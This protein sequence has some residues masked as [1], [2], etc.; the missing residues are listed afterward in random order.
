VGVFFRRS[1]LSVLQYCNVGANDG[2]PYDFYPDESAKPYYY[3]EIMQTNANGDS[4]DLWYNLFQDPRF[5]NGPSGDFYL[6]WDSPCID[7][8][9]PGSTHDPD[10][11]VIDIGA[12]YRDALKTAKDVILPPSSFI[13]SNYPNPFNSAT[14][15]EFDLPR[16][17]E[18]ELA[19]YDVTGRLVTT[20]LSGRLNAGHHHVNWDASNLPSGVYV[21]RL[22][23]DHETHGKKMVLLK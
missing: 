1:P 5:A 10:G 4:C 14:R 9:D 22:R 7:A 15:I 20:L 11:S 3:G 21:Y 12:F 17:G 6:N 18:A 8:G 19:V 2:A 13:L 16:A 23:T